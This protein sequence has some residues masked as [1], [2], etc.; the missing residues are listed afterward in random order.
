L[1]LGNLFKKTPSLGS[2]PPFSWALFSKPWLWK[3]M[4]GRV[5]NPKSFKA[6]ILLTVFFK[7][8][9]GYYLDVKDAKS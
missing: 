5:L 7:F 8:Y 2:Y 9:N 1:A 4:G 3:V 6:L